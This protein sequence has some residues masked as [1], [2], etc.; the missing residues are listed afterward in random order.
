MNDIAKK[1]DDYLEQKFN[2]GDEILD[3]SLKNNFE[4]NL[5]AHDVSPLQGQFLAIIS[6]AMNAKRI[7]E[8]GTLGGYST[9]FFARALPKDGKI[10]SLEIDAHHAKA[11][12][13]NLEAAGQMQKCEIIIGEAKNSLAQ[14]ISKNEA[15]FDLIFIDADKPN[16][17]I[18]LELALKL[19]HKGT[20]II[21]DNVIRNGAIIEENSNDDKVIGIRKFFDMIEENKNLSATALQ[22]I[23]IKGWDGFA[24]ILVD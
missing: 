9:I 4:N 5:P 19:S 10:I 21:G 14:L 6:R 17:P 11:A 20:L 15:P 8:I 24:M 3:A 23:G 12:K 7:L 2:L 16:N 1:V 18:Y 13:E 22:T